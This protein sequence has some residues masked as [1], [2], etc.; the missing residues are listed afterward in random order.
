MAGEVKVN[1]TNARFIDHTV[2]KLFVWDN[3]YDNALFDEP[4]GSGEFTLAYGTVVGR[5][6]ATGKI[7]VWAPDA[8][9]GSQFPIGVVAKSYTMAESATGVN[10]C[11]G[12][13]GDID[14]NLLVLPDGEDL[15]ST[16]TVQDGSDPAADTTNVRILRDMLQAIGFKLVGGDELTEFDNS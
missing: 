10:V 12:I 5:I 11:Y 13:S 2:K 8:E 4:D 7:A 1:G 14:Q 16:V 6:A 3:R 9:D 15:D